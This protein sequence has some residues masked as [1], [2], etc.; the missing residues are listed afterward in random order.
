MS[1]DRLAFGADELRVRT[2]RGG[3]LNALFLGGGEGLVLVQGLVVTALLGPAAVGLYG[4]VTTTAMTIVQLRRVGIDE[5]FV[6]QS[7]DDQEAEFQRA[8]AVELAV[9][10]IAALAI[11]AS[12]PVLAAV[13]EEHRLL[14]LT[15]AVSYLP[16][17]F[18]LQAPQWVF[19][20][21]MDFLRVRVLQATVPVVTFAVTV[22]LAATGFGVW[23]LVVGPL[24]GNLAA[25][26]VAR[27][28]SPYR[29]CPRFDRAAARRYLGF[30]WPIFAAALAALVLGQGQIA[31]FGLHGGLVAAGFITLA[32]TLTRYVDRADQILTTTIYPAICAVA[33]RTATL[34]ELFVKSNRLT[35]LWVGAFAGT[36]VLFARD[37]TDRILGHGWHGAAGLVAGLAAAAALGQV[38]YNWFSF[39]RARG[40]PQPQAVEALV[41]V[42]LFCAL[43]VPGLLVAGTTGFVVGRI[44][45]SVGVVAVRRVYLRRLLPGVRLAAVAVRGGAPVLLAAAP[46]LALR[47]AL[48][49]DGRPLAQIVAELAL[50]G[51][52]LAGAA[53]LLE[54]SLLV[55]LLGYVRGRSR[56]GSLALTATAAPAATS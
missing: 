48:W 44:G 16:V 33:D 19:F 15:L 52:G 47:A 53:W 34:E 13:Y 28:A 3:V 37:L 42:A 49:G 39:Y 12:A 51:A 26:V 30:S 56:P 4:I 14:A 20:R 25:V 2:A 40:Q 43:A 7:A 8:F 9:G 36:L 27:L 46:V 50:W 45:V 31:A 10:V 6:Q 5:A 11:A 32:A 54:R 23:S 38:G 21:R 17:A 35:L 29:L 55:E 1:A 41:S 22:P 24:A 18:A